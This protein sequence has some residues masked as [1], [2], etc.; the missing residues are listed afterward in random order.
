MTSHLFGHGSPTYSWGCS[1]GC[2]S[3]TKAIR[4]WMRQTSSRNPMPRS[5]Y[6]RYCAG[7][8]QLEWHIP[9]LKSKMITY[10]YCVLFFCFFLNL[11][12]NF[13]KINSLLATLQNTDPP[14][15]SD[16]RIYTGTHCQT[17]LTNYQWQKDT[18][19]HFTI[20]DIRTN[21][22]TPL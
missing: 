14:L 16:I 10:C 3:V 9:H 7:I 15:S 19:W 20:C 5:H 13:F 1:I 12:F 4:K 8:Q 18:H 6:S 17:L 21:I 2:Y 11:F 22:D